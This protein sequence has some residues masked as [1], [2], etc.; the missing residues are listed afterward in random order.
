MSSLALFPSRTA[1]AA[2]ASAVVRKV[3]GELCERSTTPGKG[4]R[5][6]L[7]SESVDLMGD[8]VVQSGMELI[9]DRIPAQIDHGGSMWDLIGHWTD[10]KR[11][12][13]RTTAELVLL[14]K[15][16]S[17]AADLVRALLDAGLRLAASI[18]FVPLASEY[19]RDAANDRITGERYQ[20]SALVEASVVVVP[21][22]PDALSLA[23]SLLSPTDRTT[24][25]QLLATPAASPVAPGQRPVATRAVVGKTSMPTLAER[26]TAA[27][28]ALVDQRDA[29]DAAQNA[30]A[31]DATDAAQAQVEELLA[32]VSRTT[33]S[34]DLLRQTEVALAAGATPAGS[35]Q[36]SGAAAAT[37]P[38]AAGGSAAIIRRR[39]KPDANLIVRSA[40]L[41]LEA[42]VTRKPFEELMRSRYPN[43][44]GTATV[45][46]VC[47]KAAQ[48]P[49]M[50]N[51]PGWAA[52]LVRDTFGAFMELLAPESVVPRIPMER[53][54]FDGYNSI[55]IPMRDPVA[56]PNLAG[57]FRAEGAPIRVGAAKLSSKTLTPKS[58]GVIGTFTNEL[59]ERSTP[60]IEQA[61]RTW[62]LEDTA[63][64]LDAYFVSLTPPIAGVS[65]GGIRANLPGNANRLSTG[66]GVAAITADLQSMV[67]AMG[68]AGLLK[69]PV[70]VMNP[71][72]ASWLAFSLTAIG[73][74]AF[75]GTTTQ[76]GTL[77]GFPVIT[78]TTVPLDI[79][80]LIDGSG[81]S[82]AGGAPSF[83]GTD[84]ATLHEDDTTPLP[85]S[86]GAV[87][88][89]PVRSLFQT[90]S[91]ALRALWEIDW[92]V[93][94]AGAVQALSAVAWH[95]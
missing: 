73:N 37:T 78:S 70:W 93:M 58:L 87:V 6:V 64:M 63:I 94:R 92:A 41:A 17:R 29:L 13:T 76:G 43:D 90:N 24:F 3:A 51:V 79:V 4:P 18:G 95:A 91:A 74:P 23:K 15:G 83:V 67:S 71:V 38:A 35:V 16:I 57:A 10:F 45:A 19:I 55:K 54:S 5:F 69:R 7:S 60:N 59:F 40:I 80:L 21:A 20:R 22:N 66:A 28:A 46:R 50:T 77:L 68:A 81:V 75:P 34:L 82:F 2:A 49:A 85:I 86:A 52:E 25:E 42:H 65:P 39:P 56:T 30:L 11:A 89:A 44:E 14:E 36:R 84:V 26:I 53:Y 88:A 33:K 27:E 32:R 61:I 9:S 8:V 72:N 12:G 31:D 1:S 62:M 47:T 48:N